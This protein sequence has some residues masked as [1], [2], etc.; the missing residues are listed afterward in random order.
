MLQP[1]GVVGAIT[2]WNFPLAMIARKV[3]T[4]NRT[5]YYMLGSSII[6]HIFCLL[7]IPLRLMHQ[8]G[9]ALASGCTIVVKPS[10]YTPLTALA[11]AELALQAGIPPVTS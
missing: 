5:G 1:V 3:L 7:T 10:E 8:A 6:A 9:P 4:Y 2:P 11:A